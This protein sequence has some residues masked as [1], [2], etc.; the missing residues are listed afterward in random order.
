[1]TWSSKMSS[2]VHALHV[3]E[4]CCVHLDQGQGHQGHQGHVPLNLL[5]VGVVPSPFR[6]MLINS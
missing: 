5:E 3:C 1:M 2:N 6:A 4:E